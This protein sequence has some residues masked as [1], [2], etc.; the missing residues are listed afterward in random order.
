MRNHNQWLS[1]ACK[2]VGGGP[3][4]VPP[5]VT[6]AALPQCSFEF[7]SQ[8]EGFGVLLL[9]GFSRHAL[10]RGVWRSRNDN[11]WIYY[12]EIRGVQ[13]DEGTENR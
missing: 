8:L 6:A 5:N 4:V 7:G 1:L 2:A 10:L 12:H 13:N 9:G 3:S 11:D